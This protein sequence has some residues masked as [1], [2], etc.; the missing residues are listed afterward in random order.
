MRVTPRPDQWQ[1]IADIRAAWN[2]GARD[3]IGV[4]ADLDL[5]VKAL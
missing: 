3:V 4:A 1:F 5:D 2:A